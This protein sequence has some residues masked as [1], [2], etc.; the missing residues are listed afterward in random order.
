[1]SS[2]NHIVTLKETASTEDVNSLKLKIAEQGGVILDEFSLIKG[3]SVKLTQPV[4]DFIKNHHLVNSIEED[5][6]VKIQ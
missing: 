2:K 4:A 6:E 1:M 5:K 3:F